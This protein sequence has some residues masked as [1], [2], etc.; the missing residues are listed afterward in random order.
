MINYFYLVKYNVVYNL[1]KK[2]KHIFTPDDKVISHCG[3]ESRTPVTYVMEF[4]ITL[5]SDFQPLTNVTKSFP[6]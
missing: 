1:G 6:S 5:I 2:N 3:G 4:F